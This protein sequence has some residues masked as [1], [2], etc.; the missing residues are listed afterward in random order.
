[1]Y[2]PT[3]FYVNQ[4]KIRN[5]SYELLGPILSLALAS[6]ASTYEKNQKNHVFLK[7]HCVARLCHT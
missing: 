7:K 5:L 1:M 4:E 2:L 3:N 6:F